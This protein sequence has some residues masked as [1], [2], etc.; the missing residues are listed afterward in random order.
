MILPQYLH[1]PTRR[2]VV[3]GD[4]VGALR[5]TGESWLSGGETASSADGVSD[6][7]LT[8]DVPQLVQN[9]FEPF[10]GFPQFGQ[11]SIVIPRSLLFLL[12]FAISAKAETKPMTTRSRL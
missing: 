2:F 11:T 5:E 9:L 7:S 4:A 12:V 1:R 3:E 6:I 10:T 8:R